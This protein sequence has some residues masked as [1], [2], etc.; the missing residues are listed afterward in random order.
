MDAETTHPEPRP[1]EGWLTP[2]VRGIGPKK[3]LA[4][5]KRHGALEQMPLD[6]REAFG[7]D[8]DRLRQIYLAPEVR[9]DYNVTASQ[10]DIDGVVRFLCEERAFKPDRVMAARERA[11]GPQRLF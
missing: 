3:A 6:I 5:V 7:T 9:D 11:F 8:L 4:L 1:S 2:G 10:C